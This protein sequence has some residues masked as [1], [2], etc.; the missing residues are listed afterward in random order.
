LFNNLKIKTML[1]VIDNTLTNVAEN[2]SIS[3]ENGEATIQS[4][5]LNLTTGS[6]NAPLGTFGGF[7]VATSAVTPSTTDISE[8]CVRIFNVN[9]QVALY[10]NW[11]G[12]ITRLFVFGD[13]PV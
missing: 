8:N 13:V 4:L 10:I 11:N 6:S 1:Q 5:E 12:V 9:G 2:Q 3:L 7:R